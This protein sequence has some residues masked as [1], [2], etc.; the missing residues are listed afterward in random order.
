[1]E[2]N[3]D[4]T[5]SKIATY[6]DINK[7][8][9]SMN[10]KETNYKEFYTDM[11]KNNLDEKD[12]KTKGKYIGIAVQKYNNA[13]STRGR[14]Q[15]IYNDLNKLDELAQSFDFCMLGPYSYFGHSSKN[16]NV[17]EVYGFVFEIDNLSRGNENSEEVLGLRNLFLRIETKYCPRP[18][19]ITSSGHGVHL[20]FIFD[21]PYKNTYQ[22]RKTLTE[23]RLACID[24]IWTFCSVDEDV[25]YEHLFQKFRMVGTPTKNMLSGESSYQ[26]VRAFKTGEA[27][28]IDQLNSIDNIPVKIETAYTRDPKKLTLAEAKIKYPNWDPKHPKTYIL[29]RAVYDKY[30]ELSKLDIAVGFRYYRLFYLIVYGVKCGLSNAEIINDLEFLFNFIND[31]YIGDMAVL[32]LT[33]DDLKDAYDAFN[34]DVTM[35]RRMRKEYIEKNAHIKFNTPRRNKRKQDVHLKIIRNNKRT[36]IE[37]GEDNWDK[38][39]RPSKK[40]Q[41]LQFRKNN[42]AANKSQCIKSTGISKVTVYR[43]WDAINENKNDD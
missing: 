33:T 8:L 10:F 7:Y 22:F 12:K 31:R 35:L 26:V 38:G 39:G 37:L 28:T 3:Q 6:Y 1:M 14:N 30:L 4:K 19:Y 18:T 5:K 23:Y 32:K 13:D 40:D 25:Q 21:K 41:I 34:A 36:L 9:S 42:P 20:Y 27:L 2:N 29:N 17:A 43:W 15:F 11:F 16:E 24:R